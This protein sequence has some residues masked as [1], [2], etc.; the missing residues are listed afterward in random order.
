VSKFAELEL[1]KKLCKR[2]CFTQTSL[3]RPL[4]AKGKNKSTN[5]GAAKKS[6]IE[7]G[8]FQKAN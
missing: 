6:G 2:H 8:C 5:G 3:H 7:E 4:A 1:A